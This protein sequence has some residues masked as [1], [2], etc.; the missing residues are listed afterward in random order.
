MKKNKKVKEVS[1]RDKEK[2]ARL[3]RIIFGFVMAVVLF[4]ALVTIENA[5]IKNEIKLPTVVATKSISEKTLVE[6]D[7]IKDFFQ[8]IEMPEAYR[9]SNALDSLDA[10]KDGVVVLENLGVNGV[11]GSDSY[12]SIDDI[13]L[14]IEDPVEVSINLGSLEN[15]VAGKVRAGD[16]INISK[17]WSEQLSATVSTVRSEY[18]VQNAFVVEAHAGTSEVSREDADTTVTLI[19]V[20]VPRAKELAINEA[21][22]NGTLRVGIVQ[23]SD[24]TEYIISG[25]VIGT[26]KDTTVKTEVNTDAEVEV[27]GTETV[28]ET[29]EVPVEGAEIPVAD[30]VPQ[31]PQTETEENTVTE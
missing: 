16:V 19:T 21:L 12:T 6:G 5:V 4:V 7:Q 22:T 30:A 26:N 28:E 17:V 24:G 8:V 1:R 20:Y 29:T 18:I 9:P 23:E 15:A 10:L 13:I 14:G 31:A 27:E 3:N 2:Q 11:L 25:D